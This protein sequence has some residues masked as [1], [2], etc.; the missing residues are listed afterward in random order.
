MISATISFWKSTFSMFRNKESFLTK[1]TLGWIFLFLYGYF[2]V[3]HWIGELVSIT[4]AKSLGLN[5][6]NFFPPDEVPSG[7]IVTFLSFKRNSEIPFTASEAASFLPLFINSIST[8]FVILPIT[9]QWLTS[10]FDKKVVLKVLPRI[11]IS[12]QE[13]WFE[14]IK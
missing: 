3:T 10:I 12:N 14:I 13:E 8:A 6:N 5:L 1:G 9:G 4:L 7:K 11:I 2:I